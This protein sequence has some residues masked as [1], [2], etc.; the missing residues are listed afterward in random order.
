MFS[1]TVTDVGALTWRNTTLNANVTA[2]SAARLALAWFTDAFVGAN[3]TTLMWD[4]VSQHVTATATGGGIDVYVTFFDASV[5]G[6]SAATWRNTTLVASLAAASF[7][8][9]AISWFNSALSGTNAT[10]LTWDGVSQCVTATSSGGGVHAVVTFFSSAAG[11]SALAWRS[12]MLDAAVSASSFSRVASVW[13]NGALVAANATTLTWNGVTQRV[14]ATSTGDFVQCFLVRF[15]ARVTGVCALVWRNTTLL[16]STLTARAGISVATA[17]FSDAFIGINS[18]TL[19][20]YGVSQRVNANA[21]VF[22][23]TFV[24][25]FRSSVTGAKG[26]AWRNMTCSHILMYR[27]LPA[28]RAS[29]P[30]N[31]RR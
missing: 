26:L 8:D 25:I 30:R 13:F 16:A 18:T 29:P 17:W 24:S 7:A 1:S 19:T 14:N 31:S 12:T 3:A 27:I 22:A 21:S 11:V 20:W 2:S 28:F 4:G 10:T 9:S 23:Q 6:V 5:V 15:F